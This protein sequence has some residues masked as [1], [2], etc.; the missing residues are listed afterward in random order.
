MAQ[1]QQVAGALIGSGDVIHVDPVGLVVQ[2]N[3]AA[4]HRPQSASL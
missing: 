3:A 2:G 4:H 1:V